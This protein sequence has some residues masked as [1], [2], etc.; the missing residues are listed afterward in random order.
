VFGKLHL[1]VAV[2]V[3]IM[4]AAAAEMTDVAQVLTLAV[5]AVQDLHYYQQAELV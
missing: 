5:A 1:Q 3:A 4:A 2:V